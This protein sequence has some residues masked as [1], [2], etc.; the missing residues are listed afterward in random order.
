MATIEE[1]YMG[2]QYLLSETVSPPDNIKKLIDKIS[3]TGVVF[4]LTTGMW[5][6]N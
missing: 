2:N 6:F 3:Q 1:W 4:D 5:S